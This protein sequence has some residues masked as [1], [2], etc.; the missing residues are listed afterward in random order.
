[1]NRKTL[2]A[3]VAFAV[4]GIIAAVA[5]RQ[6]EKGEGAGEKERPLAKMDPAAL[7]TI[8]VTRN[9]KTTTIS[10]DGSKY[11]VTA[12]GTFAAD[13]ATA[14]T[15]FDDVGKLELGDLVTENKA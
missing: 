2:T 10:K 6:P 9:G 5:L 13:E 4:L 3:V 12:P 15:A 7:D 8:V 11:T 1:M 14:K